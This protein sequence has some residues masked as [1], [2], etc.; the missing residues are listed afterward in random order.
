M[1]TIKKFTLSLVAL[2]L[3]TFTFSSCDAITDALS[4]EV[5]IEAPAIDFSIGGATS[6]P[7]QKIGTGVNAEYVWLDKPAVDVKTKLTEELAKNDLTIDKVKT[8][9]LTESTIDIT[10]ELNENLNLGN[11]KLYINDY[12]VAQGDGNVTAVSSGIVFEFASP[13]DIFGSIETGSM[14][15][16]I[17]SDQPKPTKQ[18]AMKLLNKYKS[19]ISLL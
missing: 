7:M 15:I 14:H 19:K 6:A 8:L 11:I 10:T 3:V 4:K 13:Y 9:L 18:L 16:K 12:L 17:T 5:E 1:K 2:T